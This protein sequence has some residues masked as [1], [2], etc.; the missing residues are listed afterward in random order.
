MK[1]H[2]SNITHRHLLHIPQEPQEIKLAPQETEDL[3]TP[4]QLEAE[5]SA[6]YKECEASDGGWGMFVTSA[7]LNH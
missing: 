6:P 2:D 1:S 4:A 3:R 7:D 5:V